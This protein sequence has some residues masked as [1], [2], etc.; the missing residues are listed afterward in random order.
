MHHIQNT[1]LRWLIA[2]A[3]ILAS[4]V[5]LLA[6]GSMNFSY[7]CSFSTTE[8]NCLIYGSAAAA[9]DVL[10]ALCPFF[11][12][13]AWRNR[14]YLQALASLMIWGV[15]LVFAAQSAI[16]HA[17]MNRMGTVSSREVAS[18]K[19]ADTRKDLADARQ[20]RGFIPKNKDCNCIRNEASVRA[21]IEKHKASRLWTL[22]AECTEMAGKTHREYCSAY[23]ALN[24]ELGN[25]TQAAKLDTRIEALR[26]RSDTQSADSTAVNSDSD[27]GAKALTFVTGMNLASAQ[28]ASIVLVAVMVLVC[29]GMGFYASVSVLQE[30]PAPKRLKI[31]ADEPPDQI[32]NA[33]L[34]LPPPRETPPIRLRA[35]PGPEWR[36]LLDRID[37]PRGRPARGELLRPKDAREALGWRFYVWLNAYGEARDHS[38]EELDNLYIEFALAD[39][40]NPW[41]SRI[42]KY[43]LKEIGKRHIDTKLPRTG[44]NGAERLT[45]WLVSSIAPDKLTPILE[46]K[47]VI[48]SDSKA[49][50]QGGAGEGSVITNLPFGGAGRPVASTRQVDKQAPAGALAKPDGAWERLQSDPQKQLEA[51]RP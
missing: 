41:G 10:L 29:A 31:A 45:R 23:Q 15:C 5:I 17:A 9:S 51:R 44:E 46:K 11:F 4:G 18:T 30:K 1:Y 16:S 34:A 14:E 42:V 50:K 2:I 35:D 43:E 47:G 21:D 3:G 19:Y 7:G 8:T 39:N 28:G 38:A 27:P 36:P 40:R 24:S 26:N 13:A 49:T 12:F 22:T 32:S 48:T 25:A 20:S 33:K 6:S 37:Y